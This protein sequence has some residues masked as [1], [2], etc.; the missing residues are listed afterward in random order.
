MK[1]A[2][3]TRNR[4]ST[5]VGQ[6]LNWLHKLYRFPPEDSKIKASEMLVAPRISECFGLVDS[7]AVSVFV[8]I[9]V[10]FDKV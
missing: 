10:V 5:R 8:V 3:T 7:I 9:L 1:M 4:S 2:V 6:K